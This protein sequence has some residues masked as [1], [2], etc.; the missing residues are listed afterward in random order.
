ME[1]RSRRRLRVAVLV[2]SLPLSLLAIEGV[3]RWR[4]W[5]LNHETL[6]EA[7]VVQ[8][9]V[10]PT[11]RVRFYDIIRPHPN[12]RII[13]ELRPDLDVEFS[14]A[15]LTTNSLGFRGPELL[16]DGP[17]TVTIVGLGASIMFGHG[18]ADGQD[19]FTKLGRWLEIRHPDRRWR[20]VNTAVPSYNAVTK[21][22]VLKEKG[23]AFEP[24]LVVLGIAS[25]NLDLPNYVRVAEDPLDPGRSFL[26]DWFREQRAI[27]AETERRR[28]VLASVD[29]NTLSWDGEV[30]NDPGK[31][32]PQYRDLVGWEPFRRALDE[33]ARLS[34]ERGFEVVVVANL[35]V[36]LAVQMLAEA[37]QR[38]F[39]VVSAMQDLQAWIRDHD[40]AE[41][42]LERYCR[43]P[44]V[45]NEEN[46]H[47][48]PMQHMLI[49]QRLGT[50]L[51]RLGVI[52][53]LLAKVAAAPAASET[54]ETG[55][56]NDR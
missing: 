5:Q 36:D 39:H 20:L 9:E 40:G 25:N 29:K 6:E 7:F 49:A 33:L 28:A 56:T 4:A 15:H 32:P 23:L 2:L 53:R 18:V 43:S 1:S 31:I 42:T 3:F 38:G 54:S 14:G 52:D 34:A 24:D 26:L 8:P 50:E 16:P 47:P 11:G 44:L 45:V 22:E 10:S 46:L 37:R 30:A 27:E 55:A 41:F 19:F 51:E 12:D 17:G 35:E 48:S 21:V 13:F